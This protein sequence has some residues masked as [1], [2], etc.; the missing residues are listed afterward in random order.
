MKLVYAFT[1]KRRENSLF[2]KL[3]KM[4]QETG[5]PS[6]REVWIQALDRF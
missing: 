1:I 4:F 3:M 6:L 5:E 2:V